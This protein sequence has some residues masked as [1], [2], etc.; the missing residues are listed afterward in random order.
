VLEGV[1]MKKLPKTLPET[2]PGITKLP[3]NVKSMA[4]ST[5]F[6]LP[7]EYCSK[8]YWLMS[9]S[10]RGNLLAA[11]GGCQVVY[12]GRPTMAS[13]KWIKECLDK[14]QKEIEAV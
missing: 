6:K 4:I 3:G 2:L 13:K 12:W 9:K 1:K 7:K 14:I 8:M 5:A 11:N 10:F